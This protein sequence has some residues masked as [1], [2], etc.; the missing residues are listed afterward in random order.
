MSP[1][2]GGVDVPMAPRSQFRVPRWF[3][4]PG[5]RG[6]PP[7]IR[8]P[9]VCDTRQ[10]IHWLNLPVPVFLISKSNLHHPAWP[11]TVP[12]WGSVLS[13]PIREIRG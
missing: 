8:R 7:A 5:G 11:T 12:Q 6:R 3:G 9:N 2:A 4:C 1:A 10:R 13:V